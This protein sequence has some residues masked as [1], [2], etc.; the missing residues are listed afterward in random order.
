[1]L[2]K[3]KRQTVIVCPSITSMG[4]KSI[5]RT[6]IHTRGSP[7]AISLLC[8]IVI[9]SN[10]FLFDAQDRDAPTQSL[11]R[12]DSDTALLCSGSTPHVW[13]TSHFDT[14]QGLAFCSPTRS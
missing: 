13:G 8:H 5:V 2:F 4:K 6:F 9:P 14:L 1:M 7:N 11:N 3:N 10:Y 12:I